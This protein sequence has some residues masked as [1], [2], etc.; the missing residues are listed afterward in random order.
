MRT[1]NNSVLSLLYIISIEK[2]KRCFGK[3]EGTLHHLFLFK[4]GLPSALLSI[5]LEPEAAS[6]FCQHQHVEQDHQSVV[7]FE[8][9][10]VGTKYAVIDLGGKCIICDAFSL[11]VLYPCEDSN[12]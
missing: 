8:P 2:A 1:L 6:L 7:V 3:L 10:K 12:C 4:A 9:P 11:I 5:A